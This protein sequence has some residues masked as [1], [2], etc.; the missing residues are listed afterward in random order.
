MVMT[1]P[2]PDAAITWV[3]LVVGLLTVGCDSSGGNLTYSGTTRVIEV[4]HGGTPVMTDGVFSLGEWDDAARIEVN[5]SLSLYLKQNQGH[6][7]VGVRSPDLVVPVFNLFISPAE[8]RVHQ[9]HISAQI[10]E[11]ALDT[12]SADAEDPDFVWGYSPQ[13]YANEI[14]WDERR[15]REIVESGAK[16]RDDAFPDVIFPYDGAEFQI[17]QS[18]YNAGEWRLR[19]EIAWHSAYDDPLVFPPGTA[20]KD[21]DGWMTL[22]F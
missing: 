2:P 10:G 11:R 12:S 17:K 6:A 16:S 3:F 22:V 20:R 19:L 21:T 13:W 18:K 4:P 15:L 9:L 14:R 1:R 8:G 5:D 7:F